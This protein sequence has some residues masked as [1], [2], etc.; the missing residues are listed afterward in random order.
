MRLNNRITQI[1]QLHGG[2]EGRKGVAPH[3]DPG[4]HRQLLGGY[5]LGPGDHGGVEPDEMVRLEA[6]GLG[7]RGAQGLLEINHRDEL[8]VDVHNL[9][10]QPEDVPGPVTGVQGGHQHR[11]GPVG[12]QEGPQPA[13][14]FLR[15]EGGVQRQNPAVGLA[16]GPE[17]QLIVVQP[18]GGELGTV[19][20]DDVQWACDRHD[21]F[22][23]RLTWRAAAVA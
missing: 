11:V 5:G 6:A 10:Q 13:F 21:S 7:V 8:G 15:G 20:Q 17:P 12:V 22:T 9:G 2:F 4:G 19:G 16:G 14:Q 3:Q 1:G 23:Y 18:A